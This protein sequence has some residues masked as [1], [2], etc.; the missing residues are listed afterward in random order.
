ME[1]LNRGYDQSTIS[2]L[3][4]TMI[5]SRS[6]VTW[7]EVLDYVK[8]KSTDHQ[9]MSLYTNACIYYKKLHVPFTGACGLNFHPPAPFLIVFIRRPHD[10]LRHSWVIHP[11]FAAPQR[12]L[13]KLRED[14]SYFL[15]VCCGDFKLCVVGILRNILNNNI[16]PTYIY[17][18]TVRNC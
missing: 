1:K 5:W 10:L 15:A 8:L 6:T 11:H 18:F 2:D 4:W 16:V 12:M 3:P 7:S 9:S 17:N 14:N 13:L